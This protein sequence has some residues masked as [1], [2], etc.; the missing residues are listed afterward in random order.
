VFTNLAA[1]SEAPTVDDLPPAPAPVVKLTDFGLSRF[2]DVRTDEERRQERERS[3]RGAD[4]DSAES[5]VDAEEAEERGGRGPLLSTRCGSEAYAAPELVIGGG[6]GGSSQS[7]LRSNGSGSAEV[8]P[9]GVYDPRET[10]AWACGVV[11]YALVVRR[12]PFGEGPGPG[13]GRL[14]RRAWLM[15]I[16]KGEWEWPLPCVDGG[17]GEEKE[18]NGGEELV[19]TGL[20][21][22]EGARRVVARLLVR[23]PR[24]RAR[25]S[26][27]WGDVWMGGDTV[28]VPCS[29]DG[30]VDGAGEQEEDVDVKCDELSLEDELML[31]EEGKEVFEHEHDVFGAGQGWLVDQEGIGEIARREV[32]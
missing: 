17:G 7:S 30:V 2:V 23:N 26:E 16:A 6:G 22:S 5:D 21:R 18:D 1:S 3:R 32:V 31:L 14:A 10:D 13:G 25:V 29:P 27:L 11:L 15:K 19:G 24:K 12:L 8:R 4:G 9:P 28:Q 20:V